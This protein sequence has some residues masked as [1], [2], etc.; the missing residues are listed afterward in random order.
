M[1]STAIPRSI[2]VNRFVLSK[3]VEFLFSLAMDASIGEVLER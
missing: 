3:G 2:P 1:R